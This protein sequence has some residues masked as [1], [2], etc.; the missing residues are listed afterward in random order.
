MSESNEEDEI[1]Q[2][3]QQMFNT[4]LNRTDNIAEGG[5]QSI[6]LL[7]QE[8]NVIYSLFALIISLLLAT[9]AKV[10]KL[11]SLTSQCCTLKK[12][13]TSE[14]SARATGLESFG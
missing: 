13:Q 3:I 14:E 9:L 12:S 5:G 4:V 6:Q 11:Q 10:V 2:I 8:K 7:S 1:L